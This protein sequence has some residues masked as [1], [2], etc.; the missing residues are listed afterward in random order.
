[1]KWKT[2][3]GRE[4]SLGTPTGA[5]AAYWTELQRAAD[6]P[7][8]THAALLALLYSDRNPLLDATLAPGRGV[9]TP[10]ALASPLFRAMLDLLGRKLVAEGTLDPQL[11]AV[12]YTVSPDDAAARLG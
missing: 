6:D 2:L 3:E 7:A 9:P 8:V 10:A 4:L 5:L 11:V 1:M 12:G